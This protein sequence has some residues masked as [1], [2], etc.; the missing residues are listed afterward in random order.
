MYRN[1][2]MFSPGNVQERQNVGLGRGKEDEH[3]GTRVVELL[4]DGE[5]PQTV[6]PL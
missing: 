1:G 4:K 5:A 6:W 2:K 3:S